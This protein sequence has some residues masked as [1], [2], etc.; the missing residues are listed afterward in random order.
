MLK[1]C[2][3]PRCVIWICEKYDISHYAFDI[4]K[5]CF[6]KNI[7]K[8]RNHKA[9]IYFAVNNHMYLILEDATRKLLVE[10]TKVKESF[11]TSLLENEEESEKSN[12]YD[13]YKYD[14]Q[15]YYKK[16]SKMKD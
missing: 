7:S 16:H 1:I 13:N 6:V 9:L 8:N 12:I 14:K 10:K 15:A 5:K 3:S 4:S 11:N 2:I